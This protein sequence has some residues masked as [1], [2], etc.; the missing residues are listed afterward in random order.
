VATNFTSTGSVYPNL[1][2]IS[3]ALAA[4]YKRAHLEILAALDV[5]DEMSLQAPPSLL[6]LSHTRLRITRAANDSRTLLLKILNV[7]SKLPS[8]TIERKIEMLDA[9]HAEVREAARR[10]MAAWPHATA[11]ADWQT[12]YGSHL[13]VAQR[14]RE[15]IARERQFIYPIL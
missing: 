12:Y 8:P 6:K 4:Q 5:M 9:L 14:W 1:R 7:L 15:V 13:E 11:Q 3:S 2:A 10:H